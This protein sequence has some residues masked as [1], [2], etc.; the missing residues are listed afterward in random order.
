MPRFLI[1]ASYTPEGL[2]GLLK[3]GGSKRVKAVKELMASVGGR[4]ESMYF[5]FG[6]TDAYL[7][8]EA[9]S[10]TAAV[11]AS[12]AASASGA[13]RSAAVPLILPEEIDEA[14]GMA[15]SY[16]PPGGKR[17]KK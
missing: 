8:I 11:A 13:V 4:L 9:P 6:D 14:V 10:N 7:I 3:D 12:L 16:A 5:A 15:V 1:K 2:Q 17:K